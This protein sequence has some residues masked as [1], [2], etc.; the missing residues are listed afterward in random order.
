MSLPIGFSSVSESKALDIGF[1]TKVYFTLIYK[2]EHDMLDPTHNPNDMSEYTESFIYGVDPDISSNLLAASFNLPPWAMDGT[3]SYTVSLQLIRN[4]FRIGELDR[5]FLQSSNIKKTMANINVSNYRLT[6]YKHYQNWIPDGDDSW[7]HYWNRNG[8]WYGGKDETLA[9]NAD[10]GGATLG[11][12]GITNNMT[13]DGCESQLLTAGSAGGGTLK[14]DVPSSADISDLVQKYNDGKN[15]YIFFDYLLLPPN[16]ADIDPSSLSNIHDSLRK[17]MPVL[18]SNHFVMSFDGR[19]DGF[20]DCISRTWTWD[21]TGIS[22]GLA[23]LTMDDYT[24]PSYSRMP[25]EC[26]IAM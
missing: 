9:N 26:P 11:L 19:W 6:E 16:D 3:F 24:L 15:N 8:Q 22:D 17:L 13:N 18:V 7:N 20:G 4:P 21:S 1:G 12:F 2:Y 14:S 23:V 5:L 25:Y 10:R